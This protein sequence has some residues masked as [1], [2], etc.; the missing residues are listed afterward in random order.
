MCES[1]ANE[2]ETFG[3]IKSE[4]IPITKHGIDWLID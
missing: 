4:G 1:T 2:R 3:Q